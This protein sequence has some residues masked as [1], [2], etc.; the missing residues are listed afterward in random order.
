MKKDCLCFAVRGIFFHDLLRHGIPL[1]F[2]NLYTMGEP[3]DLVPFILN[4][5]FKNTFYPER[6][7]LFYDLA[8]VLEPNMTVRIE[9]LMIFKFSTH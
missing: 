7:V 6:A 1:K 2:V 4:E 3:M 5:H 8:C 9:F